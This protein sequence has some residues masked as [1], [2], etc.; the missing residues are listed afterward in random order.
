MHPDLANLSLGGW[1][2]EPIELEGDDVAARIEHIRRD[3]FGGPRDQPLKHLGEAQTC[4]LLKEK[5]EWR[6][7]WWIS[8]D[9]DAL[10]Y[11]R[12]QQITTRETID[13]VGAIVADGDLT[14]RQAYDLM[15][16]MRD[17]DRALR[18]PKSPGEFR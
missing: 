2:G 9:R 17:A 4:W 10:D 16:G 7:A 12:K 8:D 14:D 11:A 1:L 6:E 18:L 5:V 15:L 13:I 3:V